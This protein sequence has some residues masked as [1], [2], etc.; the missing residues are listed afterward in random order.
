MFQ[1]AL[2]VEKNMM[3]SGKIMQKVETRKAREE[4]VLFASTAASSS[5]AIKF[6]MMLKTMEKLM[7]RMTI[8]NRPLN[9]EQNEPQ[10]RNPNF[11]RPNPPPPPQIR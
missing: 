6:E 4:N 10:L 7:D 2:E 11:R 3:A 5:N 1:D 8:Y 9:R